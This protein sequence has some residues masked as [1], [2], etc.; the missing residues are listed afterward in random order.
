MEDI[1]M[2]DINTENINTEDINTE[3]IDLNINCSDTTNKNIL[4]L[5]SPFNLTT[6]IDETKCMA[7]KNLKSIGIQCPYK[8]KNGS[9]FCGRHKNNKVDDTFDKHNLNPEEVLQIDKNLLTKKAKLAT[10]TKTKTI[11]KIITLKD[12]QDNSEL[13]KY[14]K[15][16]IR[17]SYHHYHLDYYCENKERNVDI[18]LIK[19]KKFFKRILYYS[20]PENIKAIVILQKII[21]RKKTQIMDYYR[22]PA[23]I[24]VEKCNN[25]TDFFN[26]DKLEDI[27][28]RYRI[29]YMDNDSFIY[30]FHLYSLKELLS[31]GEKNPYTL[32]EFPKILNYKVNKYVSIL[33][34][35]EKLNK[36]NSSF[37]NYKNH[38]GKDKSNTTQ[39]E[40]KNVD[41]LELA[42]N[43]IEKTQIELNKLPVKQLTQIQCSQTFSKMTELGYQVNCNWLYGK[44]IRQLSK[45]VI[46]L[47]YNY[48]KYNFYHP[49]LTEEQLLNTPL[50]QLVVEIDTYNIGTSNKF[51]FLQKIL[52]VLNY[53][54]DTLGIGDNKIT[55][56]IMVIQ[57]L[58][59]IEPYAVRSNNP[60][61]V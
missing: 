61:L 53:M 9:I 51:K 22:G 36:I 55:I 4:D 38:N 52:K 30:G 44:T 43:I 56:S 40:N 20:I 59:I 21:K 32:K 25:E 48:S 46:Y 13:N 28:P 34:K 35:W 11:S 41:K 3:D 26:F 60:W 45:F 5:E 15:K 12:Y 47:E 10:K 42:G 27:P 58:N 18:M 16:S 1:N 37:Y 31:R 8:R 23:W 2:E 57:S 17:E 49:D 24:N 50:L 29:T 14:N 54:F 19:L 33:E 39:I 6:N 7:N